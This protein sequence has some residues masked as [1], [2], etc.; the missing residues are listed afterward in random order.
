M[1]FLSVVIPT[2][3]EAE[4]LPRVVA[5]LRGIAGSIISEIIVVDANSKDGTP[6]IAEALGCKVHQQLQPGYGSAVAL[7][8]QQAQAPFVTFFDA[9]GSYDPRFLLTALENLKSHQNPHDAVFCT[10]YH[11]DAGSDDD[12]WIRSTGNYFFSFLLRVF[13]GVRLSDALHLNVVVKTQ[14]AQNLPIKSTGFDWCME[15]PIRLH[16]SGYS[17]CELPMRER[18]RLAGESKVNAFW[19]G[20][21]ILFSALK[22][23]FF[24]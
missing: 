13:F 4:C 5:E 24:F 11:P 23:R 8:L 20:W 19:D 17:Y 2:K 12:T 16:Q 6:Q 14:T 7:G 3:E 10:R 15:F 18:P 21:K 9:D 22:W 1:S